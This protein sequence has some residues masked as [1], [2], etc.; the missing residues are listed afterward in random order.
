[1]EG[2]ELRQVAG[3][4]VEEP[5]EEV[6][7]AAGFNIEVAGGADEGGEAFYGHSVEAFGVEAV[8]AFEVADGFFDVG[9]VGVLGEDCAG[10]DF[11][12]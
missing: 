5:V 4:I 6:F 11:E 3:V 1:M 7:E 9:P 10:D 12:G 8:G 2:F